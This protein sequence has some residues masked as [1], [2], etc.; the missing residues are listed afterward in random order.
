MEISVEADYDSVLYIRE[1][2]IDPDSVV[3]CNDDAGDSNH[4]LLDLTLDPGTYYVFVDGYGDG[5][6]QGSFTIRAEVSER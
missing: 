6:E 4:S 1:D 5:G 3:D 2:C